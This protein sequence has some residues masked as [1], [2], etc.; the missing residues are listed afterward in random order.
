[1]DIEKVKKQ[2]RNLV[3]RLYAMNYVSSVVYW[4]GLTGAS[5]KGINVRAKSLGIIRSEAHK[6][7]ISDEM[8]ECLIT[9]EKFKGE[10]DEVTKGLLKKVNREY[11][12]LI[13]IPMDE[14]QEYTKLCT[15]SN[16]VWEEA[17]R[18]SDFQLFAPYLEEI[19]SYLRKF[20]DYRGYEGH[21]YNTLLNDYEPGMTVDKLDSFFELLKKRIVPLVHEIQN[22]NKTIENDFLKLSYP[23][24]KQRK[25]S[26]YLLEKI[27]FDMNAGMLKES[28]H[29]FTLGLDP[30]DVRLTTHYYENDVMSAIFSTIHEG[31]HAIYEQNYDEALSGTLLANGSSSGIHESQSRMFEN[32]FGRSI[33]F[34]KYFYPKLVETFPEQLSD[35]SLEQFYE[36]INESKPSLI[37]IKAD[38]LTYSLHIM[39]RY[40]VEKALFE[41]KLNVKDLPRIWNEKM[42]EYLGIVPTDDFEGVLQDVHWSSGMFGYFPSYALGDAFAAQFAHAMRNEIDLDRLLEKGD[43]TKILYWLRENIHKYGLLKEPIEILRS[44]TGEEFNSVYLIEYLEEKYKKLYDLK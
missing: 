4:D 16:I 26:M 2:F 11:N 41:G 38:E 10:L 33:S 1:M 17:K 3:D 28:E 43:Y 18:K 32:I 22:S 31:G 9:L 21:P 19:I 23:I 37:R 5:K 20:I 25:F 24:D 36:A 7:L 40:E 42:E 27:G 14:L 29:P 15:K 13:K 12:R 39:V 6:M 8:K 35:I 44:A 34:W 30:S